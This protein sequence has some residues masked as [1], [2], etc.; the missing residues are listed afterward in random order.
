MGRIIHFELNADDP[1]RAARF[2]RSV[3]GWQIEKWE[4][5]ED[6]WLVTTGPDDAPGINGAL[7]HRMGPGIATV[8][9]VD[10]ADLDAV[11]V[12]AQE[13]GG[14]V[15]LPKMIVPGVGFLAYVQDTEGNLMGLMQA[16]ANA[17]PPAG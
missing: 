5:P 13:A 1:E 7:T 9:T 10:V 17:M 16:D 8:N 3:F 14:T 6:Y 15:A 2:Y 11:L 12:R 4:G